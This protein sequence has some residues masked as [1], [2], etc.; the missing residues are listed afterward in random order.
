MGL[1]MYLFRTK[2]TPNGGFSYNDDTDEVG[3][4]RKANA[5]HKWF[6]DNV[7][8][9]EDNCEAYEVYKEALE[10]LLNNCCTVLSKCKL[11]EKDVIEEFGRNE[12]GEII[13]RVVKKKVIEDT[14]VAE[15]ILPTT[16]GFF[17][18]CTDYDEWYIDDIK[19]TIEF[20][21]DTLKNTNFD[22]ETIVY[23]SSW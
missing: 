23:C 5:I 6:V 2:K 14:S 1:D 7:Q 11:V 9:G 10:K 3:Y 8:N 17:F 20:I 13:E 12:H 19:N 4:W 21:S 18:G 22:T 16:D 15:E